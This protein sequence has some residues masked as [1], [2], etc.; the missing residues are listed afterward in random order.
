MDFV[1]LLTN[2]AGE[3][4]MILSMGKNICREF[5]MFPTLAIEA[6]WNLYGHFNYW[7]FGNS[8][9]NLRPASESEYET[10]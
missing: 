4:K 5:V 6:G 2:G 8:E 1:F 9:T 10:L 3:N 7:D